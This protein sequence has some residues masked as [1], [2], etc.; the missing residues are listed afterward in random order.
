LACCVSDTVN[1]HLKPFGG[2]NHSYIMARAKFVCNS[3]KD[4]GWG[5]E[6]A[7]TAVYAGNNNEEDNQFAKATPSGQI[8]ITVSNPTLSDFFKPQRNYYFD[9]SECP[10]DKQPPLM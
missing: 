8:T 5:K 7:L 6:A 9:I 4:M 10:E 2:G 3:V 1:S